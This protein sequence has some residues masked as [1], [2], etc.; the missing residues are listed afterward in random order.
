[1]QELTEQLDKQREA[2]AKVCEDSDV[3]ITTAKVFA[4]V[5]HL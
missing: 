5:L 3:V 4:D 1:M 2:Q